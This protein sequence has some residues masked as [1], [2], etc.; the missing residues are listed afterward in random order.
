MRPPRLARRF[1]QWC[2]PRDLRA[3]LVDDLDEAFAVA[4]ARSGSLRARLW[5]WRQ[6]L[7]GIPWLI[8]LHYR[9]RQRRRRLEQSNMTTLDILTRDCR[10]ALR[11]FVRSPG[12]TAAAVI[13]LALGIGANTAIFSVIKAVLLQPLP[14]GEADRLVMI[15][16][17]SR[18]DT[19]THLSLAEVVSYEAEADGLEQLGAYTESAANLTGDSE[20]ERIRAGFVTTNLFDTMRVR[21]MLGRT[22]AEDEGRVDGPLVV[23]LGHGV[24]TRRFGAAPDIVGRS[25]LVNGRARTVIGVMPEGFRLPMDYHVERPTEIWLPLQFDKA[26]PGPWGSRSYYGVGRLR[27]NASTES[28]SA[29]FKTIAERWIRAGLVIDSGEV[30]LF[31]VAIPVQAIVT[32]DVR[33]ALLV[34]LGAVGCVLLIA[35]ANVI[36]LLLAKAD[37]RRREVAVRAA[38][39]A[40]Q[41][42]IARQVLTESAL[43]SLV[44]GGLGVF[45][46]YGGLRL[47]TAAKPASVP[48]V[49]EAAIDPV[50]LLF[51]T[52]LAIGTGVIFGIAPALRL[53]R[54]EPT[55]ALNE[56]ARGGTATRARRLTRRT[57]ATVQLACSV[58]LV[59]A[60]GLLVRSLLQMY[61]VDLGFDPRNVLTA[62]LQLST[63]SYPRSDQWVAF[64]RQLLQRLEQQPGVRDA[65]AIRV[66]PL[67]RNIGNWSITIEGRPYLREENPNGD[68]QW[69]TPGY[70]RVMGTTLLRGRFLEES[71]REGAPPVVVINDTMAERYWPGQDALGKRFHMGGTDSK[72]PKLTIVG[73]VRTSRH[74]AVIEA[75]RAEMYLPQAQLEASIGS[76][77]SSLAVVI[78]T[79]GDPLAMTQPLKEIVRSIDPN[80]AVSEVRS[81][82][83]ITQTALAMPRFAAL[84]LG[85]F[86]A[87]ALTLAL[88]GIYSTISLL[89]SERAREIGIRMALGAGRAT[90]ARLVLREGLGIAAAGSALGVA[91]ALALTRLLASLV[92]GVSTLDPL[93]FIAV[94]SL[95]IV[96]SLVACL[97]PTRRA[98][99]VDPVEVIRSA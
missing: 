58:V 3:S 29:Q 76:A 30:K 68:F 86:A 97:Y 83:Q 73:I 99:G 15:W 17:P 63:A 49:E 59:I 26:K 35:C 37:V 44:G 62:Q 47:L 70:F 45:L 56:T 92:Y 36:N 85:L 32:G 48:R 81:M 52:L 79:E 84:L 39:G 82:E 54:P 40:T 16:S 7:T 38:V 24:W 75:P 50:V 69:T 33:F 80:L 2:A 66:L 12:F 60:A 25:I 71:D 1:L 11:M 21:P 22:F 23:T 51:T 9:R 64:Y 57:L 67:S 31:R 5:Y 41:W 89:V 78:K 6:G 55:D 65:G 88:I 4:V 93:T 95:L 19:L 34:L 91:G 8:T 18:G 87:L 72:T 96:V 14:Y 98:M 43:L 61:R 27:E 42:Q 10:Y 90:I 77:I 20:P 74:N 94:P 28:V 46:A 13:T 53:S